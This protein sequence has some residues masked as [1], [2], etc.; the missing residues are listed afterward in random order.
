MLAIVVMVAALSAADFSPDVG[1]W[2]GFGEDSCDG[3][4]TCVP[5]A[6]DLES[7]GIC[8]QACVPG[9][10]PCPRG[11]ADTEMTC[12]D[13]ERGHECHYP[14]QVPGSINSL[15]DPF[16]FSCLAGEC[17]A[18]GS[19]GGGLCL[20]TCFGSCPVGLECLPF[21][22]N[23]S[24]QVCQSPDGDTD[25]GGGCATAPTAPPLAGLALAA[26]LVRRRRR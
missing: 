21:E 13:T 9:G 17:V 5:P 2:C 10:E 24:Y 14:G 11:L 23:T 12:Q 26:L 25:E 20:E 1:D 8:T 6:H 4:A 19:G 15:C 18:I 16:T 7:F 3:G 22:L